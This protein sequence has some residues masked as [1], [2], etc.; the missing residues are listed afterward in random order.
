[1]TPNVEL[2]GW[3]KAGEAGFWTVPLE[4]WVGRFYRSHDTFPF[5][6]VTHRKVMLLMAGP[7]V[8]S[9]IGDH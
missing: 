2:R 6:F 4:R 9:Q 8:N 5:S 3:P 7:V 1:M